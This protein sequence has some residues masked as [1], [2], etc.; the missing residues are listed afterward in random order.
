MSRQKELEANSKTIQQRELVGQLKN[1]DSINANSTQSM[2]VLTILVK[3]K[4]TRINFSQGS[5]TFL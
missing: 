2:F 5:V 4:E 3:I 1:T